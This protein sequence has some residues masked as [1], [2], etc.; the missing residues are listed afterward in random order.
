MPS[1]SVV[2]VVVVVVLVVVV[3]AVVVPLR[4]KPTTAS[5]TLEELRESPEHVEPREPKKRYVSTSLV[6]LIEFS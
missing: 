2:V 5:R 1:E 3:A 6:F 4:S